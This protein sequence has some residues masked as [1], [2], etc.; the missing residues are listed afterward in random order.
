MV[1]ELQKVPC[2][3]GWGEEVLLFFSLGV[4]NGLDHTYII[5]FWCGCT[6]KGG[7]RNRGE[8]GGGRGEG[9]ADS[10]P[11]TLRYC[12]T[13]YRRCQIGRPIG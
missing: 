7:G 8:G 4:R 9:V 5:I 10:R 13:A 11:D 6:K 2:P 12:L 1:G 3:K